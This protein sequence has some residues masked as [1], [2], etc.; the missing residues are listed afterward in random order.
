[1][2][3]RRVSLYRLIFWLGPG[4]VLSFLLRDVLAWVTF[5]SWYAIVVSEFTSWR[6]DSPDPK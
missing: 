5:M 6:T 3:W 2:N 1:M 4:A